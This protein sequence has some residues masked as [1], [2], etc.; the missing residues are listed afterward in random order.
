MKRD[1]CIQKT[2]YDEMRNLI[3][4]IRNILKSDILDIM[5]FIPE[6]QKTLTVYF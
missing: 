2:F 1:I 4:Y 3:I 6:S 5:M